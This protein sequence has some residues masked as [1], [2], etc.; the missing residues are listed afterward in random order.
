[1]KKHPK[2]KQAVNKHARFTTDEWKEVASVARK[3][4]SEGEFIRQATL[5]KA[6][7]L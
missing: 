2:E 1:M 4:P 6:R 5:E 7:S 3:W